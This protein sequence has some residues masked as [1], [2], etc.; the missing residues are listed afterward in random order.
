MPKLMEEWHPFKRQKCLGFSDSLLLQPTKFYG[1]STRAY[2]D[3]LETT[4]VLDTK[5]QKALP[6]LFFREQL[7]YCDLEIWDLVTNLLSGVNQ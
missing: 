5:L 4:L 2:W 6:C 1:C 3:N 7:V